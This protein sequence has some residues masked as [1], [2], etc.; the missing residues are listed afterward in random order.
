MIQKLRIYQ[1]LLLFTLSFVNLVYLQMGDNLPDSAY[2]ISS[3]TEGIGTISYYFSSLISSIYYYTGAWLVVPFLIYAF[4]YAFLLSKRIAKTDLF[5]PFILVLIFYGVTYLISPESIG[6]GLLIPSLKYLDIT[7]V[8]FSTFLFVILFFYIC[9]K[10]SFLM[11]IQYATN[12][13]VRLSKASW[14]KIGYVLRNSINYLQSITEKGRHKKNGLKLKQKMVSMLKTEN[15]EK[16]SDQKEAPSHS[17]TITPIFTA[18]EVAQE[19]HLEPT[20]ESSVA[21][22]AKSSLENDINNEINIEKEDLKI[23]IPPVAKEVKKTY[24]GTTNFFESK[25]L[26]NCITTK[27]TNSSNINPDYAYFDKIT[28][29]IEEKLAEFNIV[30]KII[31]ILKGPVV[32]TFELD[33]GSGVKVSRVTGLSD[34]IGLALNGAPIRIVYPMKGRSTIGIEVPRNPRDIIF[35]DEVLRSQHFNSSRHRLPVAMG[36]DAF[37][38]VSVVDLASMPHMLVA[39]ATGAGKSVFV[40]TLLVSLIIK[41]SPRQMKLILIDP[42]QL[43][44]ALYQDLPHLMLPVITEAKSASIA[45]LWAVQEMER[46]Y[47]ILKEM[48]V[49]N[50]EGFNKKVKSCPKESLIRLNQYY[51]GQEDEGYELPYLVIIID[52]FADLILTKSGKEIEDNVNRLAAKARAAGIHIVLATQRPSTDVVTGVIKANFPTRVAFRVTT[53]TDSRVILDQLGA[54]KLLGKGDMLYKH[55]VDVMRIHSAFVEEEEIEQLVDKLSTY[56]T[57]FNSSAIN[58]MESGGEEEHGDVT[59]TFGSSGLTG[60]TLY[61]QAV[62]VVMEQ[63]SASAS[64]LQRRLRVGYNRAAN[65]IEEMERNG[66]VGPQQGSKPR[67]IMTGRLE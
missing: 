51:E 49:K 56:G 53:A 21:H 38:E 11:T 52:E 30:A 50:I 10:G 47:T 67:E 2:T 3:N 23:A 35:L 24:R 37:G 62:Q 29:A 28:E 7:L 6:N 41:M 17:N 34:D 25:D 36:R 54:E 40:N 12:F 66:I 1:L 64:M 9:L 59:V 18:G 14:F 27:N 60:D 20:V 45:L 57:N 15:K 39:G 4:L 31:N 48:G 42:K 32:D 26:I 58:F 19:S 13:F 63:G 16:A 8:G 46:R 65:L 5:V 43:E 44:L 33:L 55:G 61:D 22:G